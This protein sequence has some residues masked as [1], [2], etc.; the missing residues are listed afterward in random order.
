MNDTLSIADFAE[1]DY[2]SGEFRLTLERTDTPLHTL[3]E[4]YYS[5]K[6]H[7]TVALSGGLDSQFS[8]NIAKKYADSASAVTFRYMWQGSVVNGQDVATAQKLCELLEMDHIIED[9]DIE[10][11]LNT[12]LQE[13][14][15]HYR[16]LSPHITVQMAAIKN[17]DH[18]DGTLLLGGE[19]PVVSKLSDHYH[20]G[21]PDVAEHLDNRGSFIQPTNFYFTHYAPFHYLHIHNGIDMIR[22]PLFVSPQIMYAGIMHNIAVINNNNT[23]YHAQAGIKNSSLQYKKLYYSSV[24]EDFVFIMPLHKHT[25]F[26]MLNMHL[27]S[28]TGNYDEFDLRYRQPLLKNAFNTDWMSPALMDMK[29]NVFKVTRTVLSGVDREEL[30]TQLNESI[31]VENPTSA[32]IYSFNW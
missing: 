13:Y 3:L 16:S 6:G 7:I 23:V 1:L 24:C 12:G 20:V 19:F 2:T 29:L 5:N 28:Q 14:M 4:E 11:V 30:N 17:S 18:I 26:E 32:N 27:A 9:F 15:H 10:P 31:T 22:D 8:A 21:I 25:G